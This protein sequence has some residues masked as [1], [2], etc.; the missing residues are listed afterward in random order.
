MKHIV[1]VLVLLL[2]ASSAWAQ[3]LET[4]P[5]TAD[6]KHYR[7]TEDGSE[8]ARLDIDLPKTQTPSR[9]FPTIVIVPGLA[10]LAEDYSKIRRRLVLQGYAAATFEWKGNEDYDA[11]DW[12]ER[13]AVLT[14]LLL[15]EDRK[16]GSRLRGKINEARLGIMGHSLGAAVAVLAADRDDRFK[17]LA[18]SGP[19]GRQSDY[20]RKRIS[21]P[22]IAIDGSLDH[23]TPPDE[24]S[25]EILRRATTRYTAH[26]L[27]KDANHRNSPADFDSDYVLD[28]GRYVMKPIPFWPFVTYVYDFP[29]IDGLTPITGRR[30][31][32]ITFPYFVGWFDRFVAGKS[33][34][35]D[36]ASRGAQELTSGKLSQAD[37]S[38]AL[39]G[40]SS[41][42]GLAG[43]LGQ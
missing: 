18:I 4:L 34:A 16:S 29:K 22:T 33:D 42:T 15:A 37:F 5:T 41:S 27:V 40:S 31:R 26:L 2:A 24:H 17:A 28:S 7:L 43:A 30:H 19:G 11:D 13:L 9:G 32:A 1:S 25:G 10:C 8:P 12:D 20:L 35:L 3:S 39:K 21:I 23:A 14:D 38:D 6:A 36:V